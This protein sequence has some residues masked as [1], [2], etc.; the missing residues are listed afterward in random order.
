MAE[1]RVLMRQVRGEQA[2]AGSQAAGGGGGAMPSA[3]AAGK[4]PVRAAQVVGLEGLAAGGSTPEI[5]Q[6]LATART[7]MANL[8]QV[9]HSGA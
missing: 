7:S 6:A 1:R 5:E 3:K 9:I 4:A 8:H 2:V